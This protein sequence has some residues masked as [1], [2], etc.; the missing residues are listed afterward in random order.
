MLFYP[1]TTLVIINKSLLIQKFGLLHHFGLIH[2]NV[3]T[4]CN[5]ARNQFCTIPLTNS[6][7][8]I[9]IYN[10]FILRVLKMSSTCSKNV[11]TF[12]TVYQSR[13]FFS[14]VDILCYYNYTAQYWTIAQLCALWRVYGR[15]CQIFLHDCSSRHYF[16]YTA[17][18]IESFLGIH[19]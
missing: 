4:L 10:G 5:A 16:T 19:Q 9:F 7:V 6:L 15:F 13:F 1:T 14:F 3:S 18:L 8:L 2:S 17:A 11:F 12:K